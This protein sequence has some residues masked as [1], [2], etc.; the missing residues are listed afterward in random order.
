MITPRQAM[1]A[2]LHL[3]AS[4]GTRQPATRMLAAKVGML[5]AGGK[6]RSSSAGAGAHAAGA[7][8]VHEELVD[9]CLQLVSSSLG[10]LVSDAPEDPWTALMSRFHRPS[11]RYVPPEDSAAAATCFLS[12]RP[13][14]SQL[15]LSP[16]QGQAVRATA[17]RVVRLV[18]EAG[19][20]QLLA[21]MVE[22]GVVHGDIDA[23]DL[24]AA[25]CQAASSC[26]M[27]CATRIVASAAAAAAAAAVAGGGGG[28]G[29]GDDDD[30]DSNA[31]VD[32]FPAAASAS[33][34]NNSTAAGSQHLA[35]HQAST[36][37]LSVSRVSCH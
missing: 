14:L 9:C 17:A 20:W 16:R 24:A 27:E 37:M 11:V 26:Q 18:Q 5:A 28:S 2:L 21:E 19:L 25:G 35:L 6:G 36:T 3:A 34:A 22:S 10:E 30:G 15:S 32:A 8:G 33:P 12:L 31:G 4:E 13:F 7:V 1:P 29:G 23:G